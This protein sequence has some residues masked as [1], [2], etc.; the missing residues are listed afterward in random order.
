MLSL[1][2]AAVVCLLAATSLVLTLGRPAQADLSEAFRLPELFEIMAEE[3]R[4]SV[5]EEDTPILEGRA[6]RAWQDEV[7]RIYDPA[8]LE[9]AFV[10]QLEHALAAR[11]SARQDALDFAR[12][13]LGARIVGLEISARAALLDAEIDLAARR[14][15]DIARGAPAADPDAQRLEQVRARIAA[16]DLVDLNVSLGLNTSFAYYTGLLEEN[17]LE[18]MTAQ[19]LLALVWAQEDPIRAEVTDW[20]ESY[21]FMA[22]HPLSDSE[23]DSYITYVAT[24]D[25]QAFNTAMFQAFGVVFERVSRQVGRALGQRM[26]SEEL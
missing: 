25:A 17:E 2:H 26:S 23:M 14:R 10:V 19:D 21:Y 5:L 15:L 12:S 24:E 7:A 4:A 8:E 18:G 11:P 16:N 20:I 3:G 6:L 22:F 1:R 13:E 9:S